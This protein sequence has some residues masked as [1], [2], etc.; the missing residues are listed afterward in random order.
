M[1]IYNT[2]S[3]EV[4]HT[5]ETQGRLSRLRR[6]MFSWARTVDGFTKSSDYR[7]PMVTLTY[8]PGNSWSAN[9]IRQ[10]M[11]AIRKHLKNRLVA[12]AW[13]AEL[14]QRG[15][16]HYHVLLVARRGSDIPFPD[17]SGMWSHGSSGIDPARSVYYICSDYLHKEAQ[18]DYRR[19]P[20]GCRSH[21]VWVS[22]DFV[23]EGSRW[24]MYLDTLPAWLSQE[25]RE[26][27]PLQRV[28]RRPGGGWVTE[29]G[30][31]L[32]SPWMSE[33][34]LRSAIRVSDINQEYESALPWPVSDPGSSQLSL[35]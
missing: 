22:R 9:H 24:L 16:V 19:F 11:L 6:R 8:A 35:V 2:D 28:A 1:K 15:A 17:S 27:F 18:K 20:A 26:R 5:N 25:M 21:A 14:Q 30:T 23:N 29:D 10:Y 34:E 33:F 31:V 4:F 12:Y 3:G 13:V 7:M 32:H